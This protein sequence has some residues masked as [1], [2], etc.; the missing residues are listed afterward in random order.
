MRF[1]AVILLLCHPAAAASLHVHESAFVPALDGKPAG[2][3]TWSAR[4]ETAPRTFV[5][6]QHYRMHPGSLAISGNGNVAEHGGWERS[7]TGVEPRSWYRFT[8]WYQADSVTAESW[9]VVAR[10]DWRTGNKRAGQPDYAYQATREGDWTKVSLYAQ[11][12]EKADGVVL[13]FYLSNAPGGTVWWDDISLDRI[14]EPAPRKVTIA[15]INLRPEHTRSAQDSVGRFVEAVE[16]TVPGKTD[17]ILLPEGITVVGTGKSYADVAEAIPGPTTARLGELARRRNS[18]IAAGIVE[19]EGPAVY[20]TAVLIDRAG[21]VAGKYRK[22]YLPREEVEGGLTPGSSYPVFHTDFGT[23]GMMICYDVFYSDPARALASQGAELILMPIWGGDE[24]LAKA[25][26]IENKVFL[27]ASGYDHPTYIMDPDGE[28]I[29][30]A[31]KRGTA[32]IA[33]IDLNRRYLDSWLGDMH[34]RRMKELR[35]DVKQPIPG[36]VK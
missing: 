5:D 26:A 14:A 24:N 28:R 20:N 23:V 31:P 9:Q 36:F 35:V 12:P 17:V 4:P 3:T 2:W 7:I 30:Q 22:V 1:W 16:S 6:P 32:A 13:Q 34:G 11:A 29:S 15:S 25:R 27:I 10:L 18:Y 33:T 21:K 19:R 8:A